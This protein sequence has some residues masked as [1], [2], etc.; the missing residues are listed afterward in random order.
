MKRTIL[1]TVLAFAC[2][3]SYPTRAAITSVGAFPELNPAPPITL[4]LNTFLVPVEIAGATGLQNW[5]FDLLFNNTVVE[6]VD[7]LDG[8]S[9]IYGAEFAPGD[10]NTLSFILGGFPFNAFGLVDDVAGSYPFLLDGVSGDGV[11]AYVLFRF[12]PGQDTNNPSIRV[13]DAILPQPV[14]EPDSLALLA[15]AMLLLSRRGCSSPKKLLS[16]LTLGDA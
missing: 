6:V 15:V 3:V 13:T 16:Q 2:L 14:P 12:L 5:Q 9:G 11:L 4:P 7:P 10:P 1:L 8:S